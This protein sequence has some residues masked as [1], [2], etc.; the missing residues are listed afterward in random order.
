[1]HYKRALKAGTIVKVRGTRTDCSIED[2]TRP[3]LARGWCSTHYERWRYSE[4]LDLLSVRSESERFWDMVDF[5]EFGTCSGSDCWLY[6]GAKSGK[7]YSSFGSDNG[8]V[9]GHLFAYRTLI[10]PVPDGMELDHTCHSTDKSCVGGNTCRH[11]LCVN[12][13]HLE[14]VTH[15][16]NV[17]RARRRVSALKEG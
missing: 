1:M 11:R 17:S 2:C 10:G 3:L 14:P 13:A 8:T 6:R 15:A 7:G 12:P 5:G 4:R 16:T 9:S